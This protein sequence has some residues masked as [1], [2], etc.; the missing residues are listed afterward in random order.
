MTKN[1]LIDLK[2]LGV[3]LLIPAGFYL[4]FFLLNPTRFGN[5]E[6]MFLIFQ[7]SL[8]PTITSLGLLYIIV[9][10]LFDFSIGSIL[11]LAALVGLKYSF[12]YG[13]MGLILGCLITAI[14]LEAFNGVLFSFLKIPSL[15]ITV[16]TLLIYEPIGSFV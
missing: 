11:V 15:I 4:F 7:Q 1:W 13:Y 3:V 2:N 16:G 10:G 12:L 6:S 9:M 14:L 5:A 8:V